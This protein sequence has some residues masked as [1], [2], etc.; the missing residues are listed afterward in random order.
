MSIKCEIK[1]LIFC[2]LSTKI[3]AFMVSF[4]RVIRV[5]WHQYHTSGLESLI[6]II[7][8]LNKGKWFLLVFIFPFPIKTMS[9]RAIINN[10]K[11][12]VHTFCIGKIKALV[13]QARYWPAL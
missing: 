10:D 1:D 13:L 8:C 3:D 12:K 9:N 2:Q 4:D 6:D 7:E 5:K 11:D